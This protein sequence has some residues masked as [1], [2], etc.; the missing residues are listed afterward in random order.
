MDIV[1]RLRRQAMQGV[2]L[3]GVS[4]LEEQAA[5]EIESLR[6]LLALASSDDA[7]AR[8]EAKDRA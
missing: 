1:E 3:P 5:A 4:S 2:W 7:A 6:A 8:A